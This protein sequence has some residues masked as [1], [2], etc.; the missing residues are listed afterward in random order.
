MGAFVGPIVDRISRSPALCVAQISREGTNG[1]TL[2][3]YNGTKKEECAKKFVKKIHYCMREQVKIAYLIRPA[4]TYEQFLVRVLRIVG[5][6]EIQICR[7][8]P[9]GDG[10]KGT[11]QKM[12]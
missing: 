12:S 2:F 11:G 4:V 3:L 8:N 5:S 10:R 1:N 6:P 9:K 7:R